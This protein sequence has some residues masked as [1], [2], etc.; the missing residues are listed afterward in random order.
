MTRAIG[1]AALL[2]ALIGCASPL[3]SPSPSS[4]PSPGPILI[5]VLTQEPPPPGGR[6]CMEALL[7]G[8]LV[9]HDRFGIAVADPAGFVRPV[10][11]PFGYA[12]AQ[13]D[14]RLALL[15]ERG[16]P[17]AAVGDPVRLT[18]GETSSNGAWETCGGPRVV[19]PS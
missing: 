16:L 10:I 9:A 17:V 13:V 7:E 12:A 2:L 14:G 11:W 15:D 4:S 19:R 8:V 6:P 5:R 18:G 3:A 1:L